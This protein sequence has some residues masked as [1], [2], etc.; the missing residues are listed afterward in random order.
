MLVK[1]IM[2]KKDL[3]NI[4]QVMVQR[5]LKNINLLALIKLLKNAN[6]Y[7]EDRYVK[8]YMEK[9]GIDK[10]RGGAYVCIELDEDQKCLLAQ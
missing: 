6:K 1:Q 10:V 3:M 4:Y 7:D 2:L 8:E 9:Y 5:G